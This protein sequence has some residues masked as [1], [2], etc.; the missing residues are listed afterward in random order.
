VSA[1]TGHLSTYFIE[2]RMRQAWQRALHEP[3]NCKKDSDCKLYCTSNDGYFKAGCLNGKCQK[4]LFGNNNLGSGFCA[5]DKDPDAFVRCV[6]GVCGGADGK[7]CKYDRMDEQLDPKHKN[8]CPDGCA[9]GREK[10]YQCRDGFCDL[11]DTYLCKGG[12][13]CVNGK[14]SDESQC[15]EATADKD[16]PNYCIGTRVV[17]EMSCVK[18]RCQDSV[19]YPCTSSEICVNAVCV[20]PNK[21]RDQGIG[22][23][24]DYGSDTG[25]D[26]GVSDK[27]KDAGAK[28]KVGFGCTQNSE[29]LYGLYC[30]KKFG[31]T[32]NGICTW[33]CV[34]IGVK[35]VAP[36]MPSG[37]PGG[38]YGGYCRLVCKKGTAPQTACPAGQ[39]C[40]KFDSIYSLC[41]P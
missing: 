6:G 25:L 18:G 36:Y 12:L 22:K 13:P 27:G 35:C 26:K 31:S 15:K 23:F 37:Y 38:C 10:R 2:G 4:G 29:C 1:N 32:T 41:R 21:K 30:V 17:W 14:C 19:S 3:Y 40:A 11:T 16:F 20:D 34:N 39:S 9:N 24:L 8:D 5:D 28:K 33:S 7:D